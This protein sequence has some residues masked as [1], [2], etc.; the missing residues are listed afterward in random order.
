MK[1]PTFL[2]SSLL[3]CSSSISAQSPVPLGI[4]HPDTPSLETA[5]EGAISILRTPDEP[6]GTVRYE[7]RFYES[8]VATA[9]RLPEFSEI[10]LVVSDRN[11]NLFLKARLGMRTISNLTTGMSNAPTMS[12]L[13]NQVTENSV[14]NAKD[15]R[16]FKQLE[17]TIH[18]SLEPNAL[19]NIDRSNV[20]RSEV[21]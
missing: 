4:V 14:S 15:D 2:V 13:D 7:I 12:L 11:G 5:N 10:V 8:G 3:A 16:I 9:K 20:L 21:P 6:S 18:K 19:V 17:F 1:L